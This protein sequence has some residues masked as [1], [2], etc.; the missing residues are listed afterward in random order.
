MLQL[1]SGE[2]ETDETDETDET[3]W[4]AHRLTIFMA[5][6][7]QE[8]Q[9]LVL[10]SGVVE[11]TWASD[12]SFKVKLQALNHIS[13]C[14]RSLDPEVRKAWVEHVVELLS[15]QQEFGAVDLCVHKLEQLILPVHAGHMGSSHLQFPRA[16]AKLRA[17]HDEAPSPD[18]KRALERF[19]HYYS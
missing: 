17:V 15:Q 3:A 12:A 1:C 7:S 18:V 19:L 14:C 13:Y 10:Q 8:L 6:R 2:G 11:R 5:G 4:A 9:R 16:M